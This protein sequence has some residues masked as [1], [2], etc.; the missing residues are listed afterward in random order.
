MVCGDSRCVYVDTGLSCGTPRRQVRV[1]LSVSDPEV[2]RGQRKGSYT[3]VKDASLNQVRRVGVS[4]K[5]I[6]RTDLTG[7]HVKH[8]G[9]NI[10]NY[11]LS[12]RCLGEWDAER[13]KV[14]DTQDRPP[15]KIRGSSSLRVEDNKGVKSCREDSLPMHH[16][17]LL[18]ESFNGRVS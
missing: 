11:P 4:P 17:R 6:C 15:S 14:E 8:S 5:K 1:H 13:R 16:F 12:S 10:N 9:P 3:R 18:P 2:K 7:D